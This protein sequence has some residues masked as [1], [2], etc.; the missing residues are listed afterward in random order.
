VGLDWVIS[1]KAKENKLERFIEYK[2]KLKESKVPYS[3][4]VDEY[5][6]AIDFPEYELG[7][8]RVKDDLKAAKEYYDKY[9]KN[10]SNFKEWSHNHRHMFI[11]NDKHEMTHVPQG[12][13]GGSASFR[14][15]VLSGCSEILREETI[16]DAWE[17]RNPEEMI[18]YAN[19]MENQL[20][21]IKIGPKWIDHYKQ[22]I[23]KYWGSPF[24]E[25]TTPD[26]DNFTGID[27][28]VFMHRYIIDSYLTV[29]QAIEWLKFW[30]NKGYSMR[31]WY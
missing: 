12:I 30:A 3:E 22:N 7:M 19:E 21:E 20:N 11:A 10:D 13:F 23:N 15:K 24:P 29:K 1:N 28:T 26:E 14:G 25:D 31:A 6:D 27:K 8:K 18:E 2:Q 5:E 16:H 4:L 17:D 9:I